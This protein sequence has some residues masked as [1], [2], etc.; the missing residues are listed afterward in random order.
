MDVIALVVTVAVVVT[1]GNPVS[2]TRT[3]NNYALQGFQT[4]AA[5][6]KAKPTELARMKVIIGGG[7]TERAVMAECVSYSAN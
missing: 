1:N 6:E 5:C 2:D 7:F 3:V 4:M